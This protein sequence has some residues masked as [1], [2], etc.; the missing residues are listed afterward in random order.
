[1]PAVTAPPRVMQGGEAVAQFTD[2]VG[3]TSTIF[4]YPTTQEGLTVRNE[5]SAAITVTVNA[6]NYTLQPGTSQ[7]LGAVFSSF[8][9]VSASGSQQ[10]TAS[11]WGYQ[12]DDV[13]N[14]FNEKIGAPFFS[15]RDDIALIEDCQNVNNWILDPTANTVNFLS[16]TQSAKITSTGTQVIKGFGAQS[17]SFVGKYL[18][19]PCYIDNVANI[20]AFE[21][22]FYKGGAYKGWFIVNA[23]TASFNLRNGWN[24]ARLNLGTFNSSNGTVDMNELNKSV[25]NIYFAVTA[26]ASTTVNISIDAVYA[27]KSPLSKGKYFITFDDH[28]K[29]VF[30]SAFP[31]LN[32]YRLP[33]TFFIG[34]SHIGNP[35]P[36]FITLDELRTMQQAGWAIASHGNTEL[37]LTTLATADVTT[38]LQTS[39]NWLDDNGF[40]S[41]S[42][43]YPQGAFNASILN[44]VRKFYKV[45]RGAGGSGFIMF[46]LIPSHGNIMIG[47]PDTGAFAVPAYGLNNGQVNKVLS[48][49]EYAAKNKFGYCTYSHGVGSGQDVSV[50]NFKLVIEKALELG[51]EI[52]TFES[53]LI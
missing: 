19:F 49:L 30:T 17:F 50:A 42:I 1:M 34:T 8:A 35:D 45:G 40:C 9:I 43:A 44:E 15:K 36:S 53:L 11:A 48:D 52:E 3:T 47:Q 31:I 10:F 27:V 41:S 7:T 51:L 26:K 12:R 18:E 24:R 37:N 6:T 5:G 22:R 16:G 2:S 23:G 21:V 39:K 13:R 38:E 29:N 46:P 25:E 14:N 20:Q 33:A 4:T 32:E 28:F